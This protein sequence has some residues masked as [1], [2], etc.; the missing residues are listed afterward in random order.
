MR[1]AAGPWSG[2]ISATLQSRTL[3][4]VRPHGVHGR[5]L[6]GDDFAQDLGGHVVYIR[7]GL[8]VLCPSRTWRR[9]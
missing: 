3:H 7:G 8:E 4:A 1:A 2:T 5:H 9:G 6:V